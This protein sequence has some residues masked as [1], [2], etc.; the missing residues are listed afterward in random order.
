MT[1]HHIDIRSES[2]YPVHFNA[3]FLGT[4]G[5]AVAM[6]QCLADQFPRSAMVLYFD[7]DHAATV[8]PSVAVA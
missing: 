8:Q 4:V 1:T 5:D 7:G 6:A 2:G 3:E